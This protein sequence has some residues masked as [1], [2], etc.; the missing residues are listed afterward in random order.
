MKR[1]G[2]YTGM[3][4]AVWCFAACSSDSDDNFEDEWRLKNEQAFNEIKQNP[5]YTEI[6]SPGNQGSIYY[7]VIEKGKGTKPIYYTSRVQAYYKGWFVAP[8][9][10]RNIDKGTVFDHSLFDDGLPFKLAMSSGAVGYY[11]ATSYYYTY[12]PSIEYGTVITGWTIA[13]QYMVEGDKWEI[14]IP[15]QLAYGTADKGSIPGYSTLA[16]EMEVTKVISVDEF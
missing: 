9:P 3:F 15:Y 12:T 5:E 6:K 16:F 11:P 8:A 14:W 1:I 10:E 13:L 2:F 4:L 7:K